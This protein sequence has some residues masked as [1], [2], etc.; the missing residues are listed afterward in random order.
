MVLLIHRPYIHTK[1]ENDRGVAEIIVAKNRHGP[2]DTVKVAFVAEQLLF[3]NLSRE[4]Y[5]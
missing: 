5:Q 1:A 3:R 2:T 4:D